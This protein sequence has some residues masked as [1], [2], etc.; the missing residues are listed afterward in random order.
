[1]VLNK[2]FLNIVT[3]YNSNEIISFN[4]IYW[5]KYLKNFFIKYHGHS[6]VTESIIKGFEDCQYPYSYNNF[7]EH[8]KICWVVADYQALNFFLRNKLY[9]YLIVGPNVVNMPYDHNN[10]LNHKNI[11]LIVV[12]SIWIQQAYKKY[13]QKNIFIWYAG[14]DQKY[15]QSSIKKNDNKSVLIYLKT[16]NYKLLNDIIECLR[17]L[18]ID[19]DIII[20]GKYK[21]KE[22]KNKLEKSLLSIFISISESQGIALL[23][24]WSMDVPTFVW[25]SNVKIINQVIYDFTSAAPYLNPQLGEFFEGVPDL[26]KL[27]NEFIL[28]KKKYKPRDWVMKNMTN[29]I[30]SNII[31][32][33]LKTLV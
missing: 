3:K 9:E 11:N 31:Y 5:K 14:V 26:Q 13:T 2:N 28:K 7:K 8:F 19:Y 32:K 15:W 21:K 16:K 33:Q 18:N 23:E 24:S 27:I 12:P 22:F 20:Y 1:M 6:A 4:P 10:I 30:S 29:K 17:S 25:K